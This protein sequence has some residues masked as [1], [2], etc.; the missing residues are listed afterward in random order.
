MSKRVT[1]ITGANGEMGHGLVHHFATHTD[2]LVVALDLNPLEDTLRPHCTAVIR[3]NILDQTLID[4]LDDTYDID[5]IYHLAALL[6]TSA[7]HNPELAHE[8]NVNG[9]MNLLQLALRQSSRQG[10]PVRFLFPSSIAVYGLPGLRAKNEA[11]PAAEGQWLNPTTMYGVNKL[12]CENLG[13]YMSD[14]YRQL[15]GDGTPA[16]VDFRAIRYPGLIS[17]LTVPSG[18]TSDF[19][20]EMLHHAAQG[21]PYACFVRPDTAIPFMAMPDAIRALIELAGAP[22]AQLSRRVYNIGAFSAT[23][24][25][26]HAATVA[27]FPDAQ[28]SF[29]PDVPRQ[30]IVDSW[31]ADVDDRAA[32]DDWGWQPAYDMQRAFSEYLIPAVRARYPAGETASA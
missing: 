17:A 27:A 32:R 1:L 19:G 2:R 6:S 22:R 28:I 23:A 13:V 14:H 30:G 18:G 31:P 25:E 5:G 21:L 11:A 26:I 7:E 16:L 8:V 15:A 24:A 3:G 29:E 9:T 12:Y 10:R 20:P 4:D